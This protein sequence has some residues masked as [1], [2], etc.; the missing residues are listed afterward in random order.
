MNKLMKI[1]KNPLF[2]FIIGGILFSSIVVIA[3]SINSSEVLYDNSGSGSVATNVQ[4]ALDEVYNIVDKV[5]SGYSLIAHAPDGL[6]TELIAGL[7]RYQG[8]QD[9]NHNVNNYICFGTINKNACTSDT[10]KYMYRI[11]GI[12]TDGQMKLI[13]K[14]VLSSQYQW[15]SQKNDTEWVSSTLFIGLNDDYFLNNTNYIPDN[16]WSNRIAFSDWH[17]LTGNSTI[18]TIAERELAAPTISAKIGLMYLHDY[19]YSLQTPDYS[20]TSWLNLINNDANHQGNFEWQITRKSSGEV[21]LLHYNGSVTSVYMNNS[22][23]VRPVF[24]LNSSETIASGSGTLSDPY[25]LS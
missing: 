17:Y 1:F 9:A 22:I 7:Y 25:I 4:G 8:V 12:N 2:T 23:Y 3:E 5:G 20:N 18:S 16:T 13:K 11:I 24:F 21:F 19:A 15:N 14:E 6:S 10:D